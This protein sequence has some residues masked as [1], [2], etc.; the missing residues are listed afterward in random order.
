[1]MRHSSPA[2][3]PKPPAGIRPTLTPAPGWRA[4]S[5]RL[6]IYELPGWQK[7]SLLDRPRPFMYGDPGL[8]ERQ[9]ESSWI[10]SAQRGLPPIVDPDQERS[11]WTTLDS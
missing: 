1:M 11:P 5:C 6:P 10:F 4:P 9:A 8:S 3:T 2:S 7:K